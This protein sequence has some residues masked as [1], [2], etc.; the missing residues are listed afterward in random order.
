MQLHKLIQA[1]LKLAA[2]IPVPFLT[3][4]LPV[5]A[6]P[7]LTVNSPTF[8]NSNTACICNSKDPFDPRAKM[9]NGPFKGQCINSCE[10]RTIKLL[11]ATEAAPYRPLPGMLVIANVSHKKKFWVAKVPPNA[12]E[13]VIFQMEQILNSCPLCHSQLRFRFKPG[14]EI[15]L[16]PQTTREDPTE[17][18]LTDIV[19]SVEATG[20]PGTGFDPASALLNLFGLSYR[21]V[22]LEDRAERMIATDKHQVEQL[23]LALQPE[24]KQ[25]LLENAITQAD[26]AGMELMYSLFDRNCTTELFKIIDRSVQ[27][28]AYRRKPSKNEDFFNIPTGTLISE[29]IQKNKLNLEAILEQANQPQLRQVAALLRQAKLPKDALRERGILDE[30]S[31]IPNL[32]DE[33]KK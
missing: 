11:S 29:I 26:R 8:I 4:A 12:V 16:V 22:S 33:L 10:Q 32:N 5:S 23:K 30:K 25:K 17:I 14:S 27:D 7:V 1:V 24:E 9:P 19:Y 6:L 28:D 13:D 31:R 3:F 21:L 2:F 18:R 15:T 20:I